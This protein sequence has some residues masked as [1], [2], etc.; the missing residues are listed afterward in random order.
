MK[1]K[2]LVE[3]IDATFEASWKATDSTADKVA[4]IDAYYG[5][6]II[7]MPANAVD[8][9]GV[10]DKIFAEY[11]FND[12]TN[13]FISFLDLFGGTMTTE[14]FTALY[15][16]VANKIITA[17]DIKGIGL[18][19]QKHV[20]W[21]PTLYDVATNYDDLTFVIQAYEWV[22]NPNNVDTYKKRKKIT[23]DGTTF[24]LDKLHV[25]KDRATIVPFRDTII[26]ERAN[27][28][29]QVRHPNVIE[30]MLAQIEIP[31]DDEGVY[32]AS[33][34]D[35]NISVRLSRT[36]S[37]IYDSSTRIET[38]AG[39]RDVSSMSRDEILDFMSFLASL[40]R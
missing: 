5:T 12:T 36:F 4:L 33:Y 39:P 24:E 16:A 10:F 15:N 27:P 3:A 34:T 1:L 14:Q 2:K 19:R 30:N 40:K 31:T 32:D 29:G 13:P 37:D 6:K 17:D 23:F 9:A 35:S 8:A 18:N 25:L 22:S 7:D 26:F 21:N 20:L 28:T 38:A 11:G